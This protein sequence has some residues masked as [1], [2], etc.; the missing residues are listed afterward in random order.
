MRGVLV[1]VHAR[2]RLLPKTLYAIDCFLSARVVSQAKL[3]LAGITCLLL[4]AK[5]DEFV[6]PSVS[7]PPLR[8]LFVH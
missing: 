7:L 1:Q 3:Q 2:F 8:P 5:V 6:V 4:A